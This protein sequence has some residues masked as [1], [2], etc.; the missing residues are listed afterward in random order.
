[1]ETQK[2]ELIK[3]EKLYKFVLI[4]SFAPTIEGNVIIKDSNV[5]GVKNTYKIYEIYQIYL[6]DY[7]LFLL[8]FRRYL[9]TKGF[10]RPYKKSY[11][12][13]INRLPK[14]YWGDLKSPLLNMWVI[15]TEDYNTLSNKYKIASKT[16]QSFK[17][18]V[19]NIFFRSTTLSKHL[20][21]NRTFIINQIT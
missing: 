9:G 18:E 6:L 4:Q 7:K 1:M 20:K 8:P 17:V 12:K 5:G 13:Y 14:N 15:L 10:L 11:N 19:F 2:T 16:T 3:L 21:T